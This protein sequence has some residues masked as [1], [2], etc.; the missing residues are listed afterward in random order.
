MCLVQRAQ[1]APP[2]FAQGGKP[3]FSVGNPPPFLLQI[4][5]A[6]PG[7]PPLLS[8]V[9]YD[10]AIILK[11]MHQL[12]EMSQQVNVW[13]GAKHSYAGE[14]SMSLH[15]SV[16][17]QQALCCSAVRAQHLTS[18]TRLQLGMKG[19][20]AGGSVRAAL[21]MSLDWEQSLW[22]YWIMLLPECAPFAAHASMLRADPPSVNL[23][24]VRFILLPAGPP[25]IHCSRDWIQSGRAD[26]YIVGIRPSLHAFELHCSAWQG[27]GSHED[28]VDERGQCAAALSAHLEHSIHCRL[29][30]ALR[31]QPRLEMLQKNP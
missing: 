19:V 20:R 16:I 4:V 3:G 22:L 13:K 15:Q 14:K 11:R 10:K 18:W 2:N 24:P 7:R 31:A 6:P 12:M 23:G 1:L 30:R 29:R 9:D 21:L 27:Q 8:A 25:D 26:P 17:R 28:A 5:A